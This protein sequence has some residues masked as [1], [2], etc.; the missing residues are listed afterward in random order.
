MEAVPLIG[1]CEAN[2]TFQIAG[3]S[4]FQDDEAGML[5]VVRAKAADLGAV[6]LFHHGVL[7]RARWDRFVSYQVL[8]V[9]HPGPDQGAELAMLRTDLVQ[10]DFVVLG[11]LDGWNGLKAFWAKAVGLPDLLAHLDHLNS[12]ISTAASLFN[13]SNRLQSSLNED[14]SNQNKKRK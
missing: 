3:V 12:S 8:V 11:D 6:V 2:G 4:D 13:L 9:L 10:I 5:L 14:S 7:R 1:A